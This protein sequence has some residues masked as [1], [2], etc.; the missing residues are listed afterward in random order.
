M[1]KIQNIKLFN[2]QFK[3]EE[4][5]IFHWWKS[6]FLKYGKVKVKVKKLYTKKNI[7]HIN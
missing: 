2:I 4:E 5:S 7:D 6:S 3:E 1:S